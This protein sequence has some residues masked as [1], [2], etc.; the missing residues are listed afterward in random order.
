[1]KQT[2]K[3]NIIFSS[4]FIVLVVFS[5]IFFP[6]KFRTKSILNEIIILQIDDIECIDQLQEGSYT[7][8]ISIMNRRSFTNYP[9]KI[10]GRLY[11]NYT[12]NITITKEIQDSFEILQD[13]FDIYLKTAKGVKSEIEIIQ[14][15]SNGSSFIWSDNLRYNKFGGDIR[16]K[17]RFFI[18][19]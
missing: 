10:E 15:K 17:Y 18:A 11:Y 19:W 13:G 16:I 14:V 2:Q 8:K 9:I 12:R 7:L 3:V 6:L 1:M 4:M 5:I